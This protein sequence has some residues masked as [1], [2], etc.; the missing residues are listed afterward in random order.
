MEENWRR[1]SSGHGVQKIQ[2]IFNFIGEFV[3]QEEFVPIKRKFRKTISNLAEYT[4][5]FTCVFL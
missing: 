2:I 4:F 3:P 5:L 1:K